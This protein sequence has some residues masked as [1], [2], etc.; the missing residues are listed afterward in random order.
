VTDLAELTTMRVGGPA[1]DLVVARTADEVTAAA[2]ESW[3]RGDEVLVLG[4]GSN[5]VIA[6]DGF[7][8]RVILIRTR[9]IEAT[10]TDTGVRLRVQAGEDWDALVARTV[11]EGWSGLEAL[12]GI[13]GS[14]GAAPVQNIGAYGAE[15]ADTLVAVDFLDYELGA[16]VR[17][18]ADELAL[19]YRT[20]AIKAGRQGIVL[21]V[22]FE[23]RTGG[24][25]AV[26]Y[27]QLAS[28]LADVPLG[29]TAPVAD[30]RDAVLRLRASK[31]MVLDADDPDTWSCGSFFTNPIVPENA[32]R[33]LPV[34]APRWPVQQPP[35]DVAVPLGADPVA[36]Q[37]EVGDVKL[38]AAWLIERAG[39]ARGF[40]LPGSRAAVS[41]KHTLA[42][43]NRGDA[44]AEE[45]AELARY[46]RMR[47]E[48][49]FGIGLVNEPVLVGLAL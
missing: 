3:S 5:V 40:R 12:S 33:S 38:S 1:R 34:D 14:V 7:D 31:G 9:G 46:I 29:G 17:L 26:R 10:P 48:A 13:P 28:A 23:V 15:L 16:V 41:G 8:G 22:E 2:L 21:A 30:I 19:G 36:P 35:P 37:P 20:S 27:A 45:V 43:T 25:G 11:A 18:A 47:V 24:I 32:A 49:E 42:I 44:S 39:I 4:G 6:D